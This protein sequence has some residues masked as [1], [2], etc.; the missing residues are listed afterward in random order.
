MNVMG[1][2]DNIVFI[3]LSSFDLKRE[4]INL[5]Q[6]LSTY[7]YLDRIICVKIIEIT[8]ATLQSSRWH[9]LTKY[10]WMNELI[11]I[12]VAIL[13]IRIYTYVLLL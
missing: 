12:I 7:F 10:S 3:I 1:I 4:D 6:E 9:R 11:D 5:T 13:Y 2:S 8:R